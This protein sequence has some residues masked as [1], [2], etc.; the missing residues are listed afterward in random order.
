MTKITKKEV[1]HV[2]KLA[3]LE[4]SKKEKEVFTEQLNNILT[5]MEKLNELDTTGVEPTSHVLPIRNVFKDDKIGV[6]LQREKALS[7]A[8]DRTEEFYRVPKIIE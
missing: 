4:L 8:P 7:N 1:E 2:A 6:S 3:R 5:Y